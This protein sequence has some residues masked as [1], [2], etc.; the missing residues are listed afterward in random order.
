VRAAAAILR[1]FSADVCLYP[2]SPG[3]WFVIT[4]PDLSIALFRVTAIA[5]MQNARLHAHYVK[6][7]VDIG[8][9][10]CHKW[11]ATMF[12]DPFHSLSREF[13]YRILDMFFVHGPNFLIRLSVALIIYKP[14]AGARCRSA[15]L[16]FAFFSHLFFC[17]RS[18]FKNIF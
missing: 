13:S 10:V 17:S 8:T 11:I 7:G 14:H 9:T 6:H 18:A 2:P 1:L 12:I 4:T 15:L 16:S 5:R 3:S